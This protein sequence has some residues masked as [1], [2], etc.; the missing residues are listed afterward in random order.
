MTMRIYVVP[1]PGRLGEYYTYQLE[2][3]EQEGRD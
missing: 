2:V 1:I 3:E